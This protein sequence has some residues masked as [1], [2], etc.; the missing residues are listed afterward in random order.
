MDCHHQVGNT[1]KGGRGRSTTS[2]APEIEPGRRD[3]GV[4]K[5]VRK[6]R[7]VLDDLRRQIGE[8][9]DDVS[10]TRKDLRD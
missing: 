3:E 4:D 10:L 6:D 9:S 1:R 5:G 2:R 7:S 8:V